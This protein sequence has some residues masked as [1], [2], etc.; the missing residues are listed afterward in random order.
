MFRLIGSLNKLE[1]DVSAVVYNSF[2]FL[3]I[4]YL[5]SEI[6]KEIHTNP[7]KHYI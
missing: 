3:V 6:K 1:K 4:S 2:F 5:T 7:D